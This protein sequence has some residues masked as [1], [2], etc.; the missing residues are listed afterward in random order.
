ML[1][2]APTLLSCGLLLLLLLLINKQKSKKEKSVAEQHSNHASPLSNF[3]FQTKNS[4]L[5]FV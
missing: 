5:D 1:L 3:N 4:I 2:I